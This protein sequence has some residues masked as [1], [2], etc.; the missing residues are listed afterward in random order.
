MTGTGAHWSLLVRLP[1]REESYWVDRP[2][3]P[4]SVWPALRRI[5]VSAFSL[6]HNAVLHL[7][8]AQ[9]VEEDTPYAR[10]SEIAHKADGRARADGRPP[11]RLPRGRRTEPHVAAR[12]VRASVGRLTCLRRGRAPWAHAGA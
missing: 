2:A 4:A 3:I 1:A 9:S 5:E 10:L 7:I 6:G 11:A 8:L 12:A